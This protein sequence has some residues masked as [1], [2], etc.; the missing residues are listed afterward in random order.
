LFVSSDVGGRWTR[1][2]TGLDGRQVLS[3]ALL[4]R[5]ILAGT[6][7]GIFARAPEAT[8]WSRL[9]VTL[10]GHEDR[11]RVTELISL[12]SG[13]LVA[14]TPDGVLRS[15]DGGQTWTR[16]DLGHADEVYDLAVPPR[17]GDLVAAATR[18]GFFISHDGG[19]TWHHVGAALDV[20]PHVLAFSPRNENVLFATTSG[21]LF[22]SRDQGANWQR[23]EGGLPHSDLTGIAVNPDG[24]TL[25]VS[26]FTWGGIF[27]SADGGLTWNRM[28]TEGLGSDRVWALSVDPEAPERLLAAASAGGLHLLVPTNG[29]TANAA[30]SS[31]P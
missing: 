3:L 5:T 16:P 17:G 30:A 2:G 18:S 20:T 6:D 22:R 24:R 29:S 1:L 12:A 8:T 31:R 15:P 4:G 27:R 13:S 21:G 23:L 19:Q 28:T 25:Y 7:E 9:A 26:D 11:P 14:A 10:N